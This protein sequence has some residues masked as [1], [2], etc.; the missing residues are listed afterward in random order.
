[1]HNT[2]IRKHFHKI[3]IS[4]KTYLSVC[5]ITE[6]HFVIWF[7]EIILSHLHFLLISN[8]I[9]Y[10]LVSFKPFLNRSVLSITSTLVAPEL[11]VEPWDVREYRLWDPVTPLLVTSIQLSSIVD[12]GTVLYEIQAHLNYW[13]TLQ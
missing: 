2:D 5:E 1:M 13:Y 11:K 10:E 6:T 12:S 8:Q 3:K 7:Q 4:K 9:R